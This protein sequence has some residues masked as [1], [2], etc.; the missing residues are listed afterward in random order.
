MQFS[1]HMGRA[2]HSCVRTPWQDFS[3]SPVSFPKRPHESHSVTF[4]NH[5]MASTVA[6]KPQWAWDA[7][8]SREGCTEDLPF[9][10][11][12]GKYKQAKLFFAHKL[13]FAYGFPIRSPLSRRQHKWKNAKLLVEIY[14]P[15]SC[16]SEGCLCNEHATDLTWDNVSCAS[17]PVNISWSAKIWQ[18]GCIWMSGKPNTLRQHVGLDF[19]LHCALQESWAQ[20]NTRELL[21]SKSQVDSKSDKAK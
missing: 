19:L 18:L 3:F 11:S 9:Q 12:D 13:T 14:K 8:G 17:I 5:W 2:Q 15:F 7:L 6:E 20:T 1:R 21:L 4:G 10:D 16:S